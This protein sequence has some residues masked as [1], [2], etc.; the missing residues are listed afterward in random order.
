MPAGHVCNLKN[1][2]APLAEW[3]SI[4]A[5][6]N[7]QTNLPN[8]SFERSQG[9][10]ELRFLLLCETMV[11]IKMLCSYSSIHPPGILEQ[12]QLYEPIGHQEP[13][14]RAFINVHRIHTYCMVPEQRRIFSRVKWSA[15]WKSVHMYRID[16]HRGQRIAVL[17]ERKN[18]TC[19]RTRT[20]V[21]TMQAT[22]RMLE[23][24]SKENQRKTM[25]K[26]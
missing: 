7:T 8:L 16:K 24:R 9:H 19:K 12:G 13:Q 11:Q 26:S 15:N 3:V 4:D 17:A 14:K 1:R 2:F 10:D 5:D 23:N 18:S 20:L 21:A 22:R 25:R 6:P